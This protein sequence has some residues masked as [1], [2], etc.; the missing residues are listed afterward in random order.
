[1]IYLIKEARFLNKT[2][3]LSL[4]G[5]NLNN[6]KEYAHEHFKVIFGVIIYFLQR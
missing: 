5:T 3:R 6:V 4:L 2:V 1:M